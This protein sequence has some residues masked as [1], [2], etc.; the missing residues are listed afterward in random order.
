MICY[1]VSGCRPH[2]RQVR[3]G[4]VGTF[5]KH[6]NALSPFFPLLFVYGGKTVPWV[7]FIAHGGCDHL[8]GELG[9][10]M[11]EAGVEPVRSASR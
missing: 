4:T 1:A 8:I 2:Q 3:I 11:S 10:E 6:R 7:N 9:L 5:A